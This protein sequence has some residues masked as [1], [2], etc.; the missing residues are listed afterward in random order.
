VRTKS[1]ASERLQNDSKKVGI[2]VPADV[3]SDY[4][5]IASD[6]HITV[7]QVIARVAIEF[8]EVERQA[9]R[10]RRATLSHSRQ[11][12]LRKNRNRVSGR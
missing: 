1:A 12:L 6:E 9:S 5:D 11:D 8:V 3:Y 4:E 7:A 10:S 2:L